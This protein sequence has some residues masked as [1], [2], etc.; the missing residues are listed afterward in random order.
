MQRNANGARSYDE[1]DSTFVPRH[2]AHDPSVN[3]ME[4]FNSFDDDTL[5]RVFKMGSL[6]ESEL[7]DI[8]ENANAVGPIQSPKSSEPDPEPSTFK[9]SPSCGAGKNPLD[10]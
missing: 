1:E 7:W 8:A 10:I 9:S 3:L 2:N 4:I 5:R 6:T